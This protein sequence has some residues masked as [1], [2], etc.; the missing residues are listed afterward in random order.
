MGVGEEPCQGPEAP[1]AVGYRLGHGDQRVGQ[2]GAPGKTCAR[3]ASLTGPVLAQ[4]VG[5]ERHGQRLPQ[6]DGVRKA[7]CPCGRESHCP[8]LGCP[9]TVL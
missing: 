2:V 6:A 5:E 1:G 4:E 8:S 7:L 9:P 3:A